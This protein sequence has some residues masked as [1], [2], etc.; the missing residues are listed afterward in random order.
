MTPIEVDALT[1]CLDVVVPVFQCGPY[2]PE[3]VSRVEQACGLRLRRIVLVFD[4]DSDESWESLRAVGERPS[5]SLVR[6]TKNSGQH[7]AIQI[8]LERVEAPWVC[9]M[10]CDLQDPPELLP[11]LLERAVT[12]GCAVVCTRNKTSNRVVYNI[13][14]S[15][16]GKL[17]KRTGQT[18][19][20]LS[21][22]N[23]SVIS[24]RS[25]RLLLNPMRR[26]AHYLP[27]LHSVESQIE[28]WPFERR[29]RRDGKSSYT[30][31][32]RI[33][34]AL[35]GLLQ[36]SSAPAL[37]AFVASSILLLGSIL[38]ATVILLRAGSSTFPPG[39][40]TVVI[41]LLLNLI[42]TQILCLVILLYLPQI[43]NFFMVSSDSEETFD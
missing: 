16:F 43:I 15:T 29:Q 35:T 22:V 32:T 12:A 31:A 41:L 34:H 25:A 5:V 26:G 33:T 24:K 28:Y 21:A 40:L 13:L 1:A 39:W 11:H 10:D 17:L 23:F 2:V 27:T 6:L 18:A 19:Q 14:A 7:R 42:G 38:F 8:G 3:L 20:P 37:F 30:A 36:S 4:G 9:V